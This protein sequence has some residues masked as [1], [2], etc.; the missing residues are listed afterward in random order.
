MIARAAHEGDDSLALQALCLDPWVS[1][2]SQARNI[3]K[4][5]RKEYRQYL[6]KA[7]NRPG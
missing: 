7:F 3:W 1:S 6:P 4:A 5:F 2:L